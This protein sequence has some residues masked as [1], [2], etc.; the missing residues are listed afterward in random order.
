[1][2]SYLLD[3]HI[4]LWSALE[5]QLL[6]KQMV[7]ILT[8]SNSLLFISAAS[9]WELAIKHEKGSLEL[10]KDC[11]SFIIECIDKLRLTVLPIQWSECI[12]AA[13]L[14]KFHQDPFDRMIIQHAI[15]RALS[16]VS[17]DVVF[18]KYGVKVIK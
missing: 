6:S 10:K 16:V 15:D 7:K 14:P 2:S 9:I 3:T 4:I 13:A 18:K 17:T 11:E 5:P 1:M 12:K 8:A